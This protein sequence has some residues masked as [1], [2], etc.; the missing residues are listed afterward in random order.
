MRKVA[1]RGSCLCGQV[2]YEGDQL[3]TPIEHCQCKTCRKAQASA[4]ATTAGVLRHHF[5]IT[6][7]E[8]RLQAYESSPGKLRWFCNI[9]GTHVL[10]D[11]PAQPHII[12]RV[13]TLDEDPAQRPEFHIWT[14]H[15]VEWL[16]ADCPTY[17]E[18][19]PGSA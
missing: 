1:V 11:R 9:C 2:A 5:R 12:L 16:A 6:R 14:S 10:A 18:L 7:G 19:Q 3:D 15:D 13:A 17:P 4:Y 8:E